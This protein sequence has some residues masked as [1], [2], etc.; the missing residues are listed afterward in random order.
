VGYIF[1]ADGSMF[2]RL[3]IVA[4]QIC[5]ITRN[6]DKIQILTYSNS[7]RSFKVIDFGVNRKC[8]CSFLLVINSNFGRILYR[9]RNIDA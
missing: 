9:F 6:S 2:I 5:E 3:T 1:V 4:S 7:S 8:S